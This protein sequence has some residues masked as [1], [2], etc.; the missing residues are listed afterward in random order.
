MFTEVLDVQPAAVV[1]VTVY[2]VGAS[3]VLTGEAQSVQLK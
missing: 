1:T 2:V 3:G